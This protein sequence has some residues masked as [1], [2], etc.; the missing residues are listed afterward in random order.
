[1]PA[2][3][4]RGAGVDLAADRGGTLA[5]PEQSSC[6]CP[7]ASG[8]GAPRRARR[9]RADRSAL[10]LDGHAGRPRVLDRVAERLL[11]DPER[12]GLDRGGRRR[13]GPE[14]AQLD[15][16][17]RR[18]QPLDQRFE[19]AEAGLRLELGGLTGADAADRAAGLGQRGRGQPGD[20]R[21]RLRRSPGIALELPLRDARMERDRRQRMPH[22]V[23]DLAGDPQP[24]GRHRLA[25][26]DVAQRLQ[27]LRPLALRADPVPEQRRQ[28]E[29][30][31]VGDDARDARARRAEPGDE[32]HHERAGRGDRDRVRTRRVRGGER[33]RQQRGERRE[34]HDVAEPVDG[35]EAGER[36]GRGGP[37]V[38]VH[39]RQRQRG[40]QRQ[41]QAERVG[42][43]R[44]GLDVGDLRLGE[45][46]ERRDREQHAGDEAEAARGGPW[47]GSRHRPRVC[48]APFARHTTKGV[49]RPPRPPRPAAGAPPRASSSACPT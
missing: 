10:D 6:L 9:A 35:D 30:H 26:G 13:S 14:P 4:R 2:A 3:A 1:M 29:Q 17:L 34:R 15:L 33:Q 23:V 40:H 47:R 43:T 32:G 16:Q 45:L 44:D 31:D 49:I 46:D 28:R 48:R 39:D 11:D 38:A 7:A 19:I 36:G 41:G 42:A 22:D 37:R 27:L 25:R 18:A 20:V 8:A 5:H 24:L 12:G 21:Q